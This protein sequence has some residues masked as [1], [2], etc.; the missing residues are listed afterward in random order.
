MAKSDAVPIEEDLGEK[1]SKE[2]KEPAVQKVPV[3]PY[4]PKIPFP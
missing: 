1:V 4:K 3:Q 2:K